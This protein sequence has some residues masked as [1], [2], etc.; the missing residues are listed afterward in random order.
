VTRRELLDRV[1]M[2]SSA[3]RQ[4][5]GAIPDDAAVWWQQIEALAAE[6]GTPITWVE[7]H[8]FTRSRADDGHEELPL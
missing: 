3:R 1:H 7:W 4:R 5:H 8:S 6:F 2:L